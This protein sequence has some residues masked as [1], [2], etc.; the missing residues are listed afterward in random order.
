MPSTNNFIPCP[1][2]GFLLQVSGGEPLYKIRSD[3]RIR[4]IRQMTSERTMSGALTP[5]SAAAHALLDAVRRNQ[6][7][8]AKWSANELRFRLGCAVSRS[9]M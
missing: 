4:E 2:C 1:L 7:E 8:H 6:G 3:P 9:N 5:V